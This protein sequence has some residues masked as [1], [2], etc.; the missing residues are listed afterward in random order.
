MSLKAKVEAVL[1]ITAR[2]TTPEEIAQV[3]E[4]DVSDVEEALL[5][6]IMDYGSREGALEI[7]DEDGYIIQISGEYMDIVEKLVPVELTPAILKTLSIV[8]IKEPIL[9]TE[10]IELRG[11]SAYDH[12]KALLQKGLISRRRDSN[13]RSY[14]VKTTDKFAEYFKLKG[15]DA[16]VAQFQAER[17]KLLAGEEIVDQKELDIDSD[18]DAQLDAVEQTE[19]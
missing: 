12:L 15:D 4:E 3:L 5:E 18:M 8:A 14:R 19:E 13:T 10:L 11:S 1:F 17:Q 9:Q 2:A 6:L 16:T 7:D